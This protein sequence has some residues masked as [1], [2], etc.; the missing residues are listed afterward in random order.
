MTCSTHNELTL[1]EPITES[2]DTG[3][4]V[5]S[6]VTG[7]RVS[8]SG[9]ALEYN[10]VSC[11]IWTNTLEDGLWCGLVFQDYGLLNFDHWV[12]AAGG[13]ADQRC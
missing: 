5:G 6:I 2:T 13:G 12:S 9:Q 1:E 10:L 3:R 4:F 7:D 8:P 11:G